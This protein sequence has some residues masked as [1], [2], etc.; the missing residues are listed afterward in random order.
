MN[1]KQKVAKE[2]FS[3]VVKKFDRIQIQTHYKDECWSIDLI[4]RSSLAKYNKN[5]KFIF[6]I[7]DNHTKFAW[8]IPLKD[9]SG[10]STTTA[11]KK[12][13]ETS[14]RKPEKVWS[15]RGKEFY[16]KTF[17]DFLKQN[18]IQIYSTHS[19]LKAVFVERFNRT[20]LDLIKEPMYIEGKAC[21]LNHINSALDKYNNRVHTTTRMTPFEASNKP[22]DPP[23]FVNK[24]KQPNFQ[25]GD[26]VRVPDKRNIYSKGYTTNWNRELFKIQKINP[27][28]PITYTLEDENNE[29]I[30]GKYY[31]QEL[32]RSV[33]NFESNNK[34]LESMNIFHQF[35]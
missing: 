26:Y 33:F 8:A 27:T 28:N 31:E 22:I 21:W 7:I 12:L 15:D 35:E 2:I 30:A 23:T 17:L 3:P 19:D 9:K 20:L 6:T 34:T 11:F 24:P 16:N 14:K 25:V 29:Q 10:K 5:Y 4:D 32:L 1:L 18:E 13:I